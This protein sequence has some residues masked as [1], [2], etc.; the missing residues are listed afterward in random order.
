M[1]NAQ[2]QGQDRFRVLLS[3]GGHSLSAMLA[4]QHSDLVLQGAMKENSIV[5]L[6]DFIVNTL[7]DKL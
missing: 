6:D 1:S 5:R 3:D 7:Q 4:T 2:Q